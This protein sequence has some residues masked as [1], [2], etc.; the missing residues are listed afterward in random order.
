MQ[1][2]DASPADGLRARIARGFAWEGLSKLCVQVVSWMSTIWVARLLT[3]DDYGLVATS[4]LF[5]GAMSILMDFGLGAGVITR[6]TVSDRELNQC[7]WLNIAMGVGMYALLFVS[8]PFIAAAYDLPALTDI[9]RVAGLG[10]PISGIRSVPY[11]VQLRALNY[12]YRAIIEM[13]GQFIQASLVVLLAFKGLGAWS[14]VLGYLCSQLFMTIAFAVKGPKIGR[15]TFSTRGIE[16]ILKFGVRI[17]GARGLGFAVGSADMAM[18]TALLG[19][20]SAG[21]YSVAFNLASAPLDK[22]GAIFNRVAYPAVARMNSDAEKSRRFLIQLHL[23]LLAVASPVLVGVAL[24]AP[25]VVTVLLTD[26]WAAAVPVLRVIC[27]A[28]ILRL[29]GMLL[30]VILE[31]RGRADLVLR[32][33]FVSAVALPVGFAVGSRWGLTGVTLVWLLVYPL[34]Y[35][36]LM[37]LSTHELGMRRRDL[38]T[39]AMP[40]L[41]CN[42]VMAGVVLGVREFTDDFSAVARLATSA[43]AGVIAYTT[44]MALLVPRSFWHEVRSTAAAMRK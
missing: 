2:A 39:S 36:W 30:P 41:M 29:S 3:P 14:L 42:G 11:S 9:L 1:P 6:Q 43:A 16:P 7:F 22:I 4:G 25:E 28:N 38:L 34:I 35:L 37:Q 44:S 23:G 26:K 21:V 12:R 19:A 20:R 13:T 8:A 18:I 24:V 10:L 31:A 33:Q 32:F 5:T 40:V 17:T 15:P 27:L